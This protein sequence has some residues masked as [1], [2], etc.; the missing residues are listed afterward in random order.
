[1]LWSWGD[2]IASSG[3]CHQGTCN[4]GK[5]RRQRLWSNSDLTWGFIITICSVITTWGW[6]MMMMMMWK[7]VWQMV[8]IYVSK[9]PTWYLKFQ[10]LSLSLWS[11][12]NLTY[13]YVQYYNNRCRMLI[14]TKFII[15]RIT[16][17]YLICIF[18]CKKVSG[19]TNDQQEQLLSKA[20]L[21]LLYNNCST[22]TTTAS[23]ITSPD[24]SMIMIPYY[25]KYCLRANF[26][27]PKT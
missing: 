26:N 11:N 17:T 6:S 9:W 14:E 22:C 12:L 21:R 7:R 20:K 10:K 8:F 4:S 25:A 27:Q 16:L 15:E 24:S 19:M 1:M 5:S 3:H 2:P 18:F 13:F 23:N